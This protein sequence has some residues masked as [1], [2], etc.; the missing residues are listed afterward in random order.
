M[1]DIVTIHSNYVFGALCVYYID[2]FYHSYSTVM[3]KDALFYI[4]TRIKI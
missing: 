3:Q 2:L 4:R 1:S